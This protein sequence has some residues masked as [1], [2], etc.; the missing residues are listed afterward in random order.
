MRAVIS[1]DV[2]RAELISDIAM[3]VSRW[4][5]KAYLIDAE[6]SELLARV[7][8]TIEHRRQKPGP[9]AQAQAA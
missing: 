9:E 5:K 8:K 1:D 6:I 2:L 3:T 4:Q 7:G